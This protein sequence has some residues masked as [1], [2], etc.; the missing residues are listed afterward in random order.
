ME[1]NDHR[2]KNAVELQRFSDPLAREASQSKTG[3]SLS[4]D[5]VTVLAVRYAFCAFNEVHAAVRGGSAAGG[6]RAAVQAFLFT[7]IHKQ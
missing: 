4:S 5:S 2:R 1:Q 3:I 6:G 7:A